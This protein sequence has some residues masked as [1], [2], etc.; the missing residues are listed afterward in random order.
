MSNEVECLRS[1]LKDSEEI[2]LSISGQNSGLLAEKT[3]LVCQV[4]VLTQNM[5]KLSQKSS[6]LENSLSDANMKLDV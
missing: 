4:Q 3:A 1:N 2:C 6:V 5:E